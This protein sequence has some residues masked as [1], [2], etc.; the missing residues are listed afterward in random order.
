MDMGGTSDPY[1]K[2]YLLPDKKKKF[3]TKVHRKT[4]N[5]VFNEQFTFKVGLALRVQL[6]HVLHSFVA[7]NLLL[8]LTI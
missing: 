4:L 6:R 2:V 7:G 5:P 8:L 1:V 3:E